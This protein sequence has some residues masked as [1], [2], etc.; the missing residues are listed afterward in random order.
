MSRYLWPGIS[1]KCKSSPR[2]LKPAL[3]L[4]KPDLDESPVAQ[5]VELHTHIDDNGVMR[6]RP[7]EGGLEI[8]AGGEHM[9]MRGG[10]HVMLMGLTQ[11][12][13]DGA[14]IPLTLIF[15]NAGPIALDV[16]VDNSRGQGQH[17]MGHGN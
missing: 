14:I 12:L 4:F 7:V 8:P 1:A 3:F 13:E 9:L 6:M 5:L 2:A 11:T 17:G 16:T 15:E 10:D